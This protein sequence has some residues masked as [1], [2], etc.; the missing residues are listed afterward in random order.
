MDETG[1][2]YISFKL[3]SYSDSIVLGIHKLI[4]VQSIPT[5]QHLTIYT[6]TCTHVY[7]SSSK[8]IICIQ[9]PDKNNCHQG[10]A[11]G[12][13]GDLCEGDISHCCIRQE[14]TR[15]LCSPIL[16]LPQEEVPGPLG[17]GCSCQ[18]CCFC[19]QLRVDAGNRLC[20]LSSG[21]HQTHPRDP[22]VEG[23]APPGQII[24]HTFPLQNLLF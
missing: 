21:V 1:K 15:Q 5:L 6:H 16:H 23:A 14:Y 9:V 13:C 19:Q 18:L 20:G 22:G 12:Q 3:K 4:S 24:H 8:F 2:T 11:P 17:E 10:A 7:Q